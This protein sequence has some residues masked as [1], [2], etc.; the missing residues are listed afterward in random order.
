ML[1]RHRR[2]IIIVALCVSPGGGIVAI[3]DILIHADTSASCR[4]RLWAAAYLARRFDA[5][6]IGAGSEE[7]GAPDGK[8]MRMLADEGLAG[9]WRTVTGSIEAGL[10]HLACAADLVILG[11][12]DPQR[13]LVDLAAPEDVILACGRP[14]LVVPYDAELDHVGERVLAA[15]NGGREATRAVHG[16]LPLLGRSNATMVVLID[17]PTEQEVELGRGMVRHLV[18]HGI[19]AKLDLGKSGGLPVADVIVARAA[20]HDS[21]LIV[22]GAYGHSRLREMVLGGATRDMLRSMTV[23]VLMSH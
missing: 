8:F 13:L 1:N 15:W 10:T 12:P 9:E 3:K 20:D 4:I 18:R 16:A 6:L 2:K 19:D 17:A 14:V 22:M 21:D 5:Y 11:Q 23:P 7:A